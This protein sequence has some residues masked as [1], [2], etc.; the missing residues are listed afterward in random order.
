MRCSVVV[1][2]IRRAGGSSQY[3]LF[4]QSRRSEVDRKLQRLS[5][6]GFAREAGYL[7]ST[8]VDDPF[9]DPRGSAGRDPTVGLLG[10]SLS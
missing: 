3:G 2:L 1:A 7:K 10:S 5:D 6:P 4:V 9:H 8:A